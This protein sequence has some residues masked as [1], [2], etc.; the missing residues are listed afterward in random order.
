MANFGTLKRL[1][2]RS[3]WPN[4]ATDFTP[5]LADNIQ[6][7]GK[8]LG[9][10]LELVEREAQVGDF[11]LDLHT[12]D[13]G[14][15]KT[16]VVENQ[17]TSTDHDHLG[18]LLTY[19]SGFN[20]AIV[21]WVAQEIREEHRQALQWLNEISDVDTEFFGVVIELLQIDDGNPAFNFKPVV[22]PNEWRKSKKIS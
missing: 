6:E 16:V 11:S 7:L 21:V 10:D 22:Y 20:A 9:K 4:E 2:L 15:G 18:K 17:L 5:W 1:D 19:A 14:S 12:I 3:A 8:A 13:L